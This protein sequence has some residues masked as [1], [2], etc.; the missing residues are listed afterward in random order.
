MTDEVKLVKYIPDR[1][2]YTTTK[3]GYE[4]VDVDWERLKRFKD[5]LKKSLAE[6]KTGDVANAFK[7]AGLGYDGE[8]SIAVRELKNIIKKAEESAKALKVRLNEDIKQIELYFN[9]YW[10][11]VGTEQAIASSGA[12][13]VTKGLE[14]A[15]MNK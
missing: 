15:G 8:A 4:M 1:S 9:T 14:D 7:S 13:A 6:R 3:N 2:S 10:S 11:S 5:S 12:E